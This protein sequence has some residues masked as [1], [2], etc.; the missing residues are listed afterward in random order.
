MQEMDKS[1]P[2]LWEELSK[3]TMADYKIFSV[4]RCKLKNPSNN[5]SGDF[6]IIDC[7]DWVQVIAETLDNQIVM[8]S[9][10]RFGSGKLSLELPG[11]MMDRGENVIEAAQRELEEETGFCGELAKVI[12]TLY[13]NP[14]I[15]TNVLNVVLIKNCTKKKDTHFDEFEDLTTSLI[16]KQDLIKAVAIGEISHC[17]TIAAI[18]KYMLL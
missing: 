12:A 1:Q 15:Q 3:E 17:I 13:P 10:Y 16:T 4:A 6:Y 18:A 5:K 9:Q 2:A 7:N 11:G 14:A 8:V